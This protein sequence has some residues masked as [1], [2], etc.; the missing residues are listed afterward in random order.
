MK[1]TDVKKA[2]LFERLEKEQLL[3]ASIKESKEKAITTVGLPLARRVL[4][5]VDQGLVYGIGK[6]IP[7]QMCVEH[8]V[9]YA[10]GVVHSD[11]PECVH[12]RVR[13]AK[14]ELNDMNWSDG[15]ARA[16]GLRRLAVAQLGSNNIDPYEFARW[17]IVH[18]L[19]D[20]LIPELSPL[21]ADERTARM[22]RRIAKTSSIEDMQGIMHAYTYFGVHRS[23]C[24][25]S[26]YFAL[27]EL[28]AYG[29]TY[30]G[31]DA[32]VAMRHWVKSGKKSERDGRMERIASCVEKAL[33]KCKSE[34]R[35]Y[36]KLCD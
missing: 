17:T 36:L 4:Q 21:T 12:P 16:R 10:M 32:L 28:I 31:E 22:L 6:P 27:Q 26:A 34:G 9:C 5:I 15:K 11:N 30:S 35:R 14:V 24:K 2:Q 29:D 18:L 13:D 20:I 33:I 7:G 3:K 19:R 8:A 25:E 1:K 23:V